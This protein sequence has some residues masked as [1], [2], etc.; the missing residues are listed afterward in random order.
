MREFDYGKKGKI[1]IINFDIL[2]VKDTFYNKRRKLWV[3]IK[4]LIYASRTPQIRDS[5]SK[6]E[7]RVAS[8]SCRNQ[9]ELSR[10][11]REMS[12]YTVVYDLFLS[13]TIQVIAGT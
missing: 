6:V 12:S 13:Y 4:I 5:P 8:P 2:L 9:D 10:F 1:E 3:E 7:P 11:S